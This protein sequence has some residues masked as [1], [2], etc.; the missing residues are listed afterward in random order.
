MIMMPG[1]VPYRWPLPDDPLRVRLQLCRPPAHHGLMSN[2][3]KGELFEMAT[4]RWLLANYPQFAMRH[5]EKL[6][7]GA[8]GTFECDVVLYWC[9]RIPL[10]QCR[11][12][13]ECK[14]RRHE[15]GHLAVVELYV[16]CKLLKADRG[17]IFAYSDMAPRSQ[18]LAMLLGIGIVKILPMLNEAVRIC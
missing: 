10:R 4:M 6:S 3:L 14:A 11:I 1:I 18:R 12:I 16:R 9:E 5:S 8:L 7:C 2:S 15:H 13:V 17:I